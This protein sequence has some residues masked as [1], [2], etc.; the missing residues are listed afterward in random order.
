MKIKYLWKKRYL[1]PLNFKAKVVIKDKDGHYIM[2]R[3]SLQQEDITFVNI[4]APNIGA[5]EYIKQILR[6]CLGSSAV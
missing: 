5:P 6:R 3:G 4:Y 1:F 2:I